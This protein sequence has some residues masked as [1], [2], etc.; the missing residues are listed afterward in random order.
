MLLKYAFEELKILLQQKN[1]IE[2][3]GRSFSYNEDN[4]I[5]ELRNFIDSHSDPEPVV[6]S[7]T[8]VNASTSPSEIPF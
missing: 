4:R 7:T 1:D 8:P 5:K 6:T 3:V 2:T